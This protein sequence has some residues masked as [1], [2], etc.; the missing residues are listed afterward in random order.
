MYNYIYVYVYMYIHESY[1]L[2]CQKT[3][4]TIHNYFSMQIKVIPI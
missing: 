1:N 2:K 3:L 4:E